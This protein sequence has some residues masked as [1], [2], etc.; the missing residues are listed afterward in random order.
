LCNSKD[1]Q[2]SEKCPKY[3]E[4]ASNPHAKRIA[5]RLFGSTT[6]SQSI[7]HLAETSNS[8]SQD[9]SSESS[10]KA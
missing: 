10:P 9:P 6:G 2:L 1:H 4:M 3:L 7:N 8:S 5:G